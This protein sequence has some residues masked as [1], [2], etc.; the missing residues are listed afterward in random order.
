MKAKI[1]INLSF[2]IRSCLLSKEHVGQEVFVAKK[3][4]KE[5]VSVLFEMSRM[6][7]IEFEKEHFKEDENFFFI[8]DF[9]NVNP[10]RIIILY[11]SHHF[12][13]KIFFVDYFFQ[14]H[15]TLLPENCPRGQ[16][17]L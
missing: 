2:N 5:Y 13:K 6:L 14:I 10:Q 17:S 4:M 15:M 3:I 16:V 1:G 9:K 11:S 12:E 7:K 8:C